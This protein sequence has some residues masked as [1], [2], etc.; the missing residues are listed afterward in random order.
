MKIKRIMF[1]LA[2]GVI[3]GFSLNYPVKKGM[4]FLITK[5]YRL[6]EDGKK[7]DKMYWVDE[8]YF[9]WYVDDYSFYFPER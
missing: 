2:L 3:I 6:R 1:V 7:P 8:L 9:K 5:H 4:Q